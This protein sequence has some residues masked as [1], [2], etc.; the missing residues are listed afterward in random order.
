[1][2]PDLI[3][4]RHS[5]DDEVRF[6]DLFWIGRGLDPVAGCFIQLIHFLLVAPVPD[7]ADVCG[8]VLR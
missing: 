4:Y 6:P 8:K 1:M 5:D 7:G 2:N 3:N